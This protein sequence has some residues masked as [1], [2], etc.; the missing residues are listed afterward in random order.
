MDLWKYPFYI[1]QNL[2]LL[3]ELKKEQNETLMAGYRSAEEINNKKRYI[4]K[5]NGR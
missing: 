1:L 3:W 4:V 5:Q 2:K